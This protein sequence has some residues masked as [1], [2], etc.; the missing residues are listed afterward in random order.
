MSR[1]QAQHLK[2]SMQNLQTQI[3]AKKHRNVK[4]QGYRSQ[5]GTTRPSEADLMA[6]PALLAMVADNQYASVAELLRRG[7]EEAGSESQK[8]FAISKQGKLDQLY[9]STSP[10]SSKHGKSP[11][12][13]EMRIAQN[14]LSQLDMYNPYRSGN[15]TKDI[16]INK[17]LTSLQRHEVELGRQLDSYFHHKISTKNNII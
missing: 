16:A 4:G 8:T 11:P 15:D 7:R 17:S 10:T 3:A 14:Q 1:Q 5:F 12:R 9:K 13:P 2:N 6:Q